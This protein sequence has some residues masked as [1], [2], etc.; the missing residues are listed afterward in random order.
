[1]ITEQ[2]QNTHVHSV[3]FSK[4]STSL[5]NDSKQVIVWWIVKANNTV[6]H[7]V[8]LCFVL[9][10]NVALPNF[11]TLAYIQKSSQRILLIVSVI[12][13]QNSLIK[14]VS[15][16]SPNVTPAFES[17]N[18]CDR[19]RE[20]KFF[21]ALQGTARFNTNAI[22]PLSRS[23]ATIFLSIPFYRSDY[24][25]DC[26]YANIRDTG[27]NTVKLPVSAIVAGSNNGS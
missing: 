25:A 18:L 13:T 14:L 2:W 3:K 8:F 20:Q 22:E 12:L 23:Y 26:S 5:E 19:Q 6:S 16:N 1:M 15:L 11:W 4:R 17:A 21:E 9:L 27:A 24:S 7:G 10:Q